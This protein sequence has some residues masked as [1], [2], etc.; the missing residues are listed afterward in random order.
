MAKTTTNDRLT[1][2]YCGFLIVLM[3]LWARCAW[4]QVIGRGRLARIADAQHWTSRP[5]VAARGA[6]LDRA[7]L[8]FST[9]YG[10]FDGE[11]YGLGTRRMIVVAERPA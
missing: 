5:I 6:M 11:P 3:A 8:R 4:L 1:A 2:V 9:A 7:G 10:G